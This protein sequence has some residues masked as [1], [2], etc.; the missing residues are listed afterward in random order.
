MNIILFFLNIFFFSFSIQ[1]N[2]LR[3]GF[4]A[5]QYSNKI[6][7]IQNQLEVYWIILNNTEIEIAMKSA[8]VNC[9][10]GIFFFFISKHY[11]SNS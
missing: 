10:F 9:W 5:T 6:V 7:A 3:V 11:Y 8:C 4:N 1:E 2:P